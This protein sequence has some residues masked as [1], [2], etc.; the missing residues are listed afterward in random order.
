MNLQFVTVETF[1][2]QFI[3]LL[4]VLWVLNKFVFKPYLAHLDEWEEKQIQVQADYNNAESILA[5]KQAQGDEI[6]EKARNKGNTVIEEAESLAIS[7]KDKILS[8]AETQAKDTLNAAKKQIENERTSMLSGAKEYILSAA[9]KLNE[10][11]FK[12][13]KASKDFMSKNI[14]SL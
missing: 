7:K 3:I 13:E 4:V 11:I 12:D 9:L 6:L 1:V 8:D 14:D 10:K 5:E 2:I